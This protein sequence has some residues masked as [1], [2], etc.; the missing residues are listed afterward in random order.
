MH[1]DQEVTKDVFKKRVEQMLGMP[2][3]NIRDLFGMVEHGIPYVDCEHGRLHVP[4]YARVRAVDPETL[5]DLGVGKAGL[6]QLMTP[7]LSSYPSISLLT[8]DRAIIE[9]NCPCGRSGKTFRILGRAG[10]AK[11]K[12]C[13]ITALD[14]LK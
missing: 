9:Q 6:L 3:E 2:G 10:L 1:K 13:A 7:Y 11:H 8:T 12:G 4:I 14:L 5:E